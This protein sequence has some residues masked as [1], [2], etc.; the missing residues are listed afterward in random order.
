MDQLARTDPE[1]RSAAP[2]APNGQ[3]ET[4]RLVSLNIAQ[5]AGRSGVIPLARFT[6]RGVG[7][8]VAQRLAEEPWDVLA[9]QE[10]PDE[11]RGL[12]ALRALLEVSVPGLRVVRAEL[13]EHGPAVLS[14]HPLSHGDAALFAPG[15]RDGKGYARVRIATVRGPLELVS[16]HLAVV[17]R[18]ARRAQIDRLVAALAGF[19]GPRVVVGDLNDGGDAP[20]YL[21]ERLGLRA[22]PCGP[23]FPSLR[24]ALRLDWALASPEVTVRDAGATAVFPS[25]HC[26]L[27]LTLELAP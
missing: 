4:L 27:R 9:L 22:H 1:S 15:R 3:I 10:A 2:E 20:R 19:D 6:A 11:G 25:D 12:D 24:P 5:L 18:A 23:T 7:R 17:G 14:A 26:A 16:V 21:A 8:R 13:P